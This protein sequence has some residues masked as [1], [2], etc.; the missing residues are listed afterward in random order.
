MG[1]ELVLG[2][3][4]IT[5]RFLSVRVSA[6]SQGLFAESWPKVRVEVRSGSDVCS[7][8]IS[9]TYGLQETEGSV[10]LRPVETD[11]TTAEPNTVALMLTGKAPSRGTV[12]I[13]LIDAGTGVELKKLENV[14]V[15]IAI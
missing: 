8:P 9:G 13:H 6:R 11:A 14:E 7:I 1:W 3:A 5:T 4:K 12:S 15:S 10:A 2:S